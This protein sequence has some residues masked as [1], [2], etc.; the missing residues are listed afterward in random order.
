MIQANELR[1]GNYLLFDNVQSQI[2]AI[3]LDLNSISNDVVADN[4][5]TYI[6]IS[7]NR[8][9]GI[10]MSEDVLVN[11]NFIKVGSIADGMDKW[12]IKSSN[13][14]LYFNGE[15]AGL[16]TSLPKSVPLYYLHQLQNL[17]FALIGEELQVN[18]QAT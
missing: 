9:N 1:I 17:F 15:Y 10:R 5:Y 8:I 13:F 7:S 11:A 18:Q 6:K 12:M 4:T 14:I 16:I 2:T 3:D